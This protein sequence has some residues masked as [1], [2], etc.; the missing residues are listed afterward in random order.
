[1]ISGYFDDTLSSDEVLLVQLQM[2]F[3]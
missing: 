2:I 1:M 3:H